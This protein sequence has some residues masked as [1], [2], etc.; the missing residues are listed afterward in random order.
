[1]YNQRWSTRKIALQYNCH[2][3]TIKKILEKNNIEIRNRSQAR[4]KYFYDEN[5]FEVIDTEEKAYWLGFISADGNILKKNHG[6]SKEFRV[7]IQLANKDVEHLHKFNK[8]LNGNLN[9]RQFIEKHKN[10]K[11]Y[12]KCDIYLDCSKMVSDLEN[13]GL[14]ENKSLTLKYPQNIPLKLEKHFIRGYFDGDGS[15]HYNKIKS[16]YRLSFCGTEEFL[17]NIMIFFNKKVKLYCSGKIYQLSYGGK[18]Q[19]YKMLNI[20]YSDA[21]IY[22]N[23]KYNKF[24]EA[25]IE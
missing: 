24:L 1:M 23:R 6:H 19:V 17:T 25:Y 8:S 12:S 11:E 16:D 21:N 10:G 4:K 3:Q 13:K 9:I 15:F 14:Y 22:L 5:F 2:H 20:L 18:Q 7:R